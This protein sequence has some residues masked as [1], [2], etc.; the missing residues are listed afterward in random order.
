MQHSHGLGFGCLAS[1]CSLDLGYMPLPWLL[2]HCGFVNMHFG[3]AM[4][5]AAFSWGL[6]WPCLLVQ[7]WVIF[8]IMG[9]FFPPQ[10][11]LFGLASIPWPWLRAH[12]GY[13]AFVA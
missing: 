13:K 9:F 3:H 2:P 6:L 1:R 10:M 4:A 11:R 7:C 8:P 12:K 5:L